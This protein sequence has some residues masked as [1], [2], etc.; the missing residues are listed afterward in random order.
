MEK[1]FCKTEWNSLCYSSPSFPAESPKGLSENFL[2]NRGRR[3]GG[4]SVKRPQANYQK[5]SSGKDHCRRQNFFRYYMPQREITLLI[6][7]TFRS[8]R[9][10]P[11]LIRCSVAFLSVSQNLSIANRRMNG[12]SD[13]LKNN[14]IETG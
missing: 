3:Y 1:L 14:N 9:R 8:M 2:S 7:T 10:Q 12:Y 13:A 5:I 6:W 4:S 11:L